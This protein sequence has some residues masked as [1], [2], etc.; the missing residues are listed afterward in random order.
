MTPSDTT[1]Q[2]YRSIDAHYARMF[3][4]HP[5]RDFP[6]QAARWMKVRAWLKQN[7]P[8]YIWAD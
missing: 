3:E 1:L 2:T 5:I 4:R 7:D 6:H 8:D